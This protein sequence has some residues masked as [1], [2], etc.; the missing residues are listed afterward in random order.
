MASS[1]ISI[2]LNDE[3]RKFVMGFA[4]AEKKSIGVLMKEA[5]IEKIED[6]ND[7]RAGEAAY[8]E[9]LK[10]PQQTRPISELYEKYLND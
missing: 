8:R 2:R 5:I 4:K 9:Y 6:W 3:E 7:I 10:Q 1:T